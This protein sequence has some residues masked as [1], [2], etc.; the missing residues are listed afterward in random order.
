MKYFETLNSSIKTVYKHLSK[1]LRGLWSVFPLFN[2]ID[3]LSPKDISK[4][5]LLH[6]KNIM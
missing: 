3:P 1:P 4:Q 2:S 6:L 5:I